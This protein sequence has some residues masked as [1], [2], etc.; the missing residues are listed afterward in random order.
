MLKKYIDGSNWNLMASYRSVYKRVEWPEKAYVS[1][2]YCDS[3][4][5]EIPVDYDDSGKT[6][7]KKDHKCILYLPDKKNYAISAVYDDQ[8]KIIEWY[9]DVIHS[10]GHD[11]IPYFLD[12]Y[13]DVAMS[14]EK[15]PVLLDEDELKTA[16]DNQLI[17]K[18]EYELALRTGEYIMDELVF[19]DSLL[20]DYMETQLKELMLKI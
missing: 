8:D 14:E 16:L 5:E 11:G 3:I 20:E 12:L 4:E 15:K 2:V 9:F 18:N 6:L 10:V 13:I 1:L 17:C 7:I 19:D